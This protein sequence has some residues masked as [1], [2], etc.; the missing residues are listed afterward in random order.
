MIISNGVYYTILGDGP[1]SKKYKMDMVLE[2]ANQWSL[3]Q[4]AMAVGEDYLEHYYDDKTPW[5]TAF[6]IYTDDEKVLGD[7]QVEM[8]MKPIF[9]AR[10]KK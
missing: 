6:R 9:F 8:Q 5:P 1:Y 7:Y 2:S 10:V 3:L 4:V